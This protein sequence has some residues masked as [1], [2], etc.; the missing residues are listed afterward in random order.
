MSINNNITLGSY[1]FTLNPSNYS[2]KSTPYKNSKR[3]LNGTLQTTYIVN[4]NNKTIIKKEI[5][6]SGITEN[7]LNLI[8][9]EF[10]KAENLT[11]ID[12][13]NNTLTVQFID[14]NYTLD[15]QQVNYP[16]YNITLQE[17]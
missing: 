8:L 3:S 16:T 6:I 2:V 4:D 14:Y 10:E 17:V 1:Q 13:Y 15:G 11:F 12:I 9:T 7:E 5:T